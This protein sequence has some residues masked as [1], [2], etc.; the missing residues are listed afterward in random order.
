MTGGVLI[1]AAIAVAFSLVFLVAPGVMLIGDEFRLRRMR[2]ESG[3]VVPLNRTT[4]AAGTIMLAAGV[5]VIVV[6]LTP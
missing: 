4:L 3:V 2:R 6:R 5:A 1:G